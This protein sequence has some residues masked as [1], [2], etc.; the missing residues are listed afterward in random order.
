MLCC[1]VLFSLSVFRYGSIVSLGSGACYH[2]EV[3]LICFVRLDL[4]YSHWY[5][6][7]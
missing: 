4:A 7:A 2:M 1:V 3:L 6:S 5:L